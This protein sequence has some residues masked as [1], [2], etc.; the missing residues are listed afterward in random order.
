MTLPH[1]R[2]ARRLCKGLA[3]AAAQRLSSGGWLRTATTIDDGW[4]RRRR[5][6]RGHDATRSA[7]AWRREFSADLP[8]VIRRAEECHDG[9]YGRTVT[10]KAVLQLADG[11]E[12]ECSHPPAAAIVSRCVFR[13][14][15]LWNGAFIL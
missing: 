1:G 14:G 8:P 10:A 11:A 6:T 5:R 7:A 2:F 15:W 3:E 13:R 9:E 12:I 4:R